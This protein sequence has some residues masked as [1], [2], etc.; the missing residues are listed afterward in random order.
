MTE[1]SDSRRGLGAGSTIHASTSTATDFCDEIHGQHQAELILIADQDALQ[2][3]QRS[4]V[5]TNPISTFQE[6]VGFNVCPLPGLGAL[7]RFP[8]RK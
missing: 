6:R 7:I 8:H 3:L 2:A 4:P 1:S 5:H